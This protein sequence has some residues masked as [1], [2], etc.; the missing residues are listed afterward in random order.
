MPVEFSF[1]EGITVVTLARWHYSET[2]G[3]EAR[4][5]QAEGVE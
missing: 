3:A 2:I 5:E 1:L 4:W